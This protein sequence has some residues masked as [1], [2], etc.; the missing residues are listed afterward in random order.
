M[1]TVTARPWFAVAQHASV[2]FGDYPFP[3][4]V[5]ARPTAESAILS[6]GASLPPILAVVQPSDYVPVVEP[7]YWDVLV[8]LFAVFPDMEF[9]AQKEEHPH[10]S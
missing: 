4:T 9:I 6:P 2:I 7:D 10:V 5:L 1:S 8:N 3:C